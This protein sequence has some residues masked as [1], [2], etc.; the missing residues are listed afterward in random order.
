M[1]LEDLEVY[2][3]L[4]VL[5]GIVHMIIIG[6]GKLTDDAHSKYHQY[7]GWVGIVMFLIRLGLYGY[8]LWGLSETFNKAREKVKNFAR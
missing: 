7:D 5:V 2:I 1:E 8:F 6:L 4:A 3:P